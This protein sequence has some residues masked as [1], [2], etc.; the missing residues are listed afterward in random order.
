MVQLRI[1]PVLLLLAMV[2]LTACMR[3]PDTSMLEHELQHRLDTEFT[4]GLFRLHSFTRKGSAPSVSHSDAVYLYYDT[5]LEFQRDYNLTAWQGLNLG[6]LAVVLG[7]TPAGIEGYHQNNQRGDLLLVRGRL[8]Y[9][10]TGD[11]WVN[12][13]RTPL[14]IPAKS[15]VPDTVEGSGPTSILQSVRRLLERNPGGAGRSRDGIII[16]EFSESV[17]EIDLRFARLDGML[18]FGT[19]WSGGAY[20]LFG[21]A[22]APYATEHG[23]PVF[24]YSSEGS[25]EN[26]LSLQQGHLDFALLQSDVVEV[27]YQGWVAASQL[28]QPD[29]RS[30]ASLWPEAL[31]IVTLE[32]RNIRSFSDLKGKRL[33]LGSPGSGTRFT[34]RRVWMAAGH[35]LSQVE[36]IQDHGLSTSIAALESGEVDAIFVAGAVPDPA[37]QLLTQRRDDVRLVPIDAATLDQLSSKHFAYYS[38]VI[39]PKTYPGQ[40][41]PYRTLG[42]AALLITSESTDDNDVEKFLDLV[43]D[44]ANELTHKF[45]RAGFI[46]TETSRLGISIPMHP[47]ATHF[48]ERLREK[49]VDSTRESVPDSSLGDTGQSPDN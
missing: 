31:H 35:T 25:V 13:S 27:L 41:E 36:G 28:P 30:M 48:Y 38:T 9:R 6:T 15:T 4:P 45:Y 33:A 34:A 26:G 17:K 43:V 2:T 14:K 10:K 3:G 7:A 5:E 8:S 22:F 12:I 11:G 49:Q 42:F 47:G 16:G 37:L 23:L 44:S 19:G 20:N 21:A 40:T 24:N 18:P 32:D 46:S 29:L 39:P 1:L